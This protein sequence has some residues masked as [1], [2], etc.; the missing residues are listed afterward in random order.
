MNLIQMKEGLSSTADHA[1]S[2]FR[3][4]NRKRKDFSTFRNKKDIPNMNRMV[5]SKIFIRYEEY[6][7]S[8]KITVFGGLLILFRDD[9][10]FWVPLW[11]EFADPSRTQKVDDLIFIDILTNLIMEFWIRKACLIYFQNQQHMMMFESGGRLTMKHQKT[12]VKMR[13]TK[14]LGFRT[15]TFSI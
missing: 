10:F 14:Y 12:P 2:R 7:R 6:R 1:K 9:S 13:L 4:K 5:H 15:R 8:V 3:V 11:H